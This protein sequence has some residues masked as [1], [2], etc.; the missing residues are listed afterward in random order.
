MQPF[1][2]NTTFLFLVHCISYHMIIYECKLQ[3]AHTQVLQIKKKTHCK[4]CL[5]DRA[6]IIHQLIALQAMCQY[7]RTHFC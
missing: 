7:V 1:I 5:T 3:Y 2:E 6:I 4:K